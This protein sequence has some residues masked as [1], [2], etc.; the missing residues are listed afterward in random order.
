M[1]THLP[2]RF[3]ATNVI[4]P[5]RA[6]SAVPVPSVSPSICQLQR[7]RAR[8]GRRKRTFVCRGLFVEFLKRPC[9]IRV[10][11]FS[12]SARPWSHVAPTLTK[13]TSSETIFASS[14]PWCVAHALEKYRVVS[15]GLSCRWLPGPTR[16]VKSATQ[17]LPN[18]Y[19]QLACGVSGSQ[20][21]PM[22]CSAR[23]SQCAADSRLPTA[24][25]SGAD[26]G[27]LGPA[28]TSIDAI[29]RSIS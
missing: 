15:S 13:S 2:E 22:A 1:T 28:T 14:R 9:K 16:K 25:S 4:R 26:D 10:W 24:S 19:F 8:S 20:D 5:Y 29:L 18:W 23:R 6:G 21:G 7:T 3:S 17:S 11:Y 27:R 12:K